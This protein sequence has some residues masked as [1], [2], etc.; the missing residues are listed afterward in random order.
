MFFCGHSDVVFGDDFILKFLTPLFH[1]SGLD[2]SQ[3]SHVGGDHPVLEVRAFPEESVV[4][5]GKGQYA[6]HSRAPQVEEEL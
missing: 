3:H 4:V 5:G 2:L 6:R 1:S